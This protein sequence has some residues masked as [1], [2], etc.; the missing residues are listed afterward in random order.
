MESPAKRIGIAMR[1]ITVKGDPMLSACAQAA[2]ET[3]ATLCET[4]LWSI[5][6]E[7]DVLHGFTIACSLTLIRRCATPSPA[8]SKD[9]R[10]IA[11]GVVP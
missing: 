8:G 7:G 5:W 2:D 10:V 1:S 6:G 3:G 11:A 9:H 4:L